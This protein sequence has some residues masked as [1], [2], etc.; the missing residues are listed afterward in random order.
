MPIAPTPQT[1]AEEIALD[2][3]QILLNGGRLLVQAD[4]RWLELFDKTD[5]LQKV[6]VVDASA[7]KSDL[8]Q[9]LGDVKNVE[10]W[11]LNAIKNGGRMRGLSSL[12]TGLSNLGYV[13]RAAEIYPQ[14]M[15]VRDGEINARYGLGIACGA[16]SQMVDVASNLVKAGGVLEQKD[17]Q[18][19]AHRAQAALQAL[20]VPE[21]TFR[22]MMDEAGTVMRQRELMW[23]RTAPD[24]LV[25]EVGGSPFLA[26]N[27]RVKVSP[28]EAAELTW[29]LAER[30]AEKGLM[31]LKVTVGFIGQVLEKAEAT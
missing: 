21:E 17:V 2:V 11:A 29:E 22:S 25:P 1:I 28:G 30:L 20:G 12:A 23:L 7:L 3:Q 4:E 24:L 9:L 14:L 19:L 18:M 5:K 13:S 26:L 27:Y 15:D 10:Y 8:Y 31:P 16:F 6:S